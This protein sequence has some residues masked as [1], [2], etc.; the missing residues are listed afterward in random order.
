MKTNNIDKTK[1]YFILMHPSECF[2]IFALQV[3]P[4]EKNG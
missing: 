3:V 1:H 4:Q 2:G